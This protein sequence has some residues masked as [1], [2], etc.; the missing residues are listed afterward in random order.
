MDT[1]DFV[2]IRLAV[3]TLAIG[4]LESERVAMTILGV[5]YNVLIFTERPVTV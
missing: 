2:N 1:G 3:H 4:H 5:R